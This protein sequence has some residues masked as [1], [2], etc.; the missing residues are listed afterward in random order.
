MHQSEAK[1]T[2]N[3]MHS[4][5][6]RSTA[7]WLAVIGLCIQ[8]CSTNSSVPWKVFDDRVRAID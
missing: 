5:E 2:Q 8:G 4:V 7:L 6:M 1:A 3:I